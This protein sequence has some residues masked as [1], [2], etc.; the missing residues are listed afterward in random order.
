MGNFLRV[1]G[2]FSGVSISTAFSSCRKSLRCF[3]ISNND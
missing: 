1:C 3:I 2:D